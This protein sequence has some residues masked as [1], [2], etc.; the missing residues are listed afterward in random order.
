MPPNGPR[1]GLPRVSWEDIVR[2][3]NRA[4]E[5]TRPFRDLY[6]KRSGAEGTI[7]ELKRAHGP[8]RVW[9]RGRDRV[10]MA[11]YFKV[12]ACNVKRF[13]QW[14]C[15]QAPALGGAQCALPTPTQGKHRRNVRSI[16]FHV[17]VP[18]FRLSSST[19]TTCV[20][21]SLDGLS[22]RRC[23]GHRI[24]LLPTDGG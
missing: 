22:H 13:A 3:W 16:S 8:G 15:A 9:T 7:S 6:R 2:A 11:V 5:T 24:G 19:G 18:A 20:G 12:V 10:T 17:K 14:W 21:P 1:V 4:R 23:S